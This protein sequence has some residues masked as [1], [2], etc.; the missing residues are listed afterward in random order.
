MGYDL[1]GITE[2]ARM[3]GVSPQRADQLAATPTFPQP[4]TRLSAGRIWERAD[5]R[6]WAE[7]TNRK[8]VSDGKEASP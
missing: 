7:A 3:F 4:V 6:R 8:I 1:V 2:I 5:V